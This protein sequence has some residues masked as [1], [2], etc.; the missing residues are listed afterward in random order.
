MDKSAQKKKFINL[1]TIEMWERFAFCTFNG[2]F[3]LFA[4]ST[5]FSEKSAYLIFG[6]FMA[7]AYGLPTVGGLIA[8][9]LIGIKRTLILGAVTLTI[10]YLVLALAH[11]YHTTLIAL[12]IIAIGN[13]LFK[14]NP[15]A[16]IGLIYTKNAAETNAAFTMYYMAINIGALIGTAVS[17]LIAKHTNFNVTFFLACIGMLFA[18]GNFIIKYKSFHDIYNL[19]GSKPLRLNNVVMTAFILIALLIISY[20]ML[21]FNNIAFY[22]VL[23]LTIICYGYLLVGGMNHANKVDKIKQSI[24][25]FIFIQALLFF[26]IYTQM[27][28]TLIVFAKNNVRLSVLGFGL[29]PASFLALNP[30]WI[31]VLS[32]I[33]AKFYVF[34]NKRNIHSATGDKYA[35]AMF[36]CALAFFGLII[37]CWTVSADSKI[38]GA[39][40]VLYFFLTSLAELL[41]S[42]IGLSV[43]AQYFPR[44]KLSFCMG[45]WLLAQ[46]CG[47]ALAGK[48]AGFV[49]MPSTHVIAAQSLNLF[50]KYF[51]VFALS[52][53]VVV[54]I[55]TLT[56]ILFRRISAKHQIKLS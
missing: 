19:I 44:N 39:W 36:C 6:I 28:S 49:A 47:N 14:P 2:L 29:S 52:C 3:I 11:N 15:S 25:V 35:L 43:A 9:R 22:I 1:F 50:T 4:I 32:P 17:P 41:I 21:N 38:N 30:F 20:A 54:I 45:A 31:L 12:A 16:L 23:L 37:A 46:G 51:Y 18:L 40:M 8:D 53:L 48:L 27:F 24:G 34:L 13:A 56:A 33:L 42:A 10:G 26:I 5:Y 7:L 55:F